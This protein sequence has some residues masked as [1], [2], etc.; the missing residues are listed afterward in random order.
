MTGPHPTWRAR[1]YICAPMTDK[2]V[3]WAT[4]VSPAK[5]VQLQRLTAGSHVC[6]LWP[7]LPTCAEESELVG[8]K[9]QPPDLLTSQSPVLFQ[10]DSGYPRQHSCPASS[11]GSHY[12]QE[13]GCGHLIYPLA[14]PHASR[15]RLFSFSVLWPMVLLLPRGNLALQKKKKTTKDCSLLHG[16]AQTNHKQVQSP[17]PLVPLLLPLARGSLLLHRQK[18]SFCLLW[19]SVFSGC[20]KLQKAHPSGT[21]V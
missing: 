6:N 21:W 3:H 13:K 4:L 2:E 11:T 9:H 10:E 8:G 12:P 5:I 20:S 16:P 7:N 14:S 19:E 1:W 15:P 18:V 17:G